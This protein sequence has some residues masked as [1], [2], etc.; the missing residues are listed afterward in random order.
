M[1]LLGVPLVVALLS[2]CGSSH[3]AEQVTVGMTADRVHQILGAPG[4][5][6]TSAQSLHWNYL[7][8]DGKTAEVCFVKGRVA[9]T[10]LSG[11]QAG[12]V[13]RLWRVRAC[14]Y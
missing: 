13:S 2:G 7:R 12:D 14:N 10:R 8:D 6:M 3:A 5:E 9:A 11:G 4:A 1:R